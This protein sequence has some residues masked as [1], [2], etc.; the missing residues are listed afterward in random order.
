MPQVSVVVPVYNEEEVLDALVGRLVPF[1][2]GTQRTWELVLVDDGSTDRSRERMCA[3]RDRE[4]RITIVCLSRN[5]GHQ[6]AITAGMDHA[7]GDAVVVMDADLQD[8]PEALEPMLARWDEGYDIVYAVRTERID[9]GLFKRASASVFYRVLA[10]LTPIEIPVDAGDF[11]LMSRRAVDALQRM[12][13]RARYVRG[14]VAWLGFRQIAV[15]FQR[16]PRHAGRTKYPLRKVLSFGADGIFSFSALPLR[17]ATGLGFV[18]AA[19]A[20]AYFGY[21]ASMKLLVGK[22]VPGWTSIVAVVVFIGSAQLIC[23]GIIGEYVARIY[24]EV[25]GRPLYFVDTVLRGE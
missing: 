3:L 18:M 13:E 24:E 16:Q 5:F 12:P 10:A 2:E 22:A 8:P 14:M 15:P 17:V 9:E 1:L 20:L 7:G 23:L 21:A 25:K 11:R 19:A 6:L 4:P